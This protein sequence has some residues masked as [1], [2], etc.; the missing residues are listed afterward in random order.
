MSDSITASDA[1]ELINQGAYLLDVRENDEFQA[2]RSASAHHIRLSELPDVF[3]A[4]PKEQTIVCVCRSGG[5]SAR[6]AAFLAEQGFDTL[7]LE[8]GMTAWHEAELPM[9]SDDGE[10]FVA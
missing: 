8:G 5:R 6:A 9:V 7:N 1:Y 4:L 10:P 2:G 3:D